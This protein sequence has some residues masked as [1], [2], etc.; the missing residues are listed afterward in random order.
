MSQEV[1]AVS[2]A[3]DGEDVD[4]LIVESLA[5]LENKI[6]ERLDESMEK[7]ILRFE[8]RLA[9][10]LERLMMKLIKEQEIPFEARIVQRIQDVVTSK[11][12]KFEPD[13]TFTDMQN[14]VGS[15]KKF[16]HGMA[17]KVG[18]LESKLEAVEEGA[19]KSTAQ[20]PVDVKEWESRMEHTEQLLARHQSAMLKIR[21]YLDQHQEY[22]DSLTKSLGI[23]T[24]EEQEPGAR[25]YPVRVIDDLRAI[26]TKTYRDTNDQLKQLHSNI[27]DLSSTLTRVAE[28]S[29]DWRWRR[30]TVMQ[31]VDAMQK[32]TRP[33]HSTNAD[34]S[35]QVSSQRTVLEFDNEDADLL[36][37]PTSTVLPYKNFAR[38]QVTT[39]AQS[40]S[41]TTTPRTR[42]SASRS[43]K[44]SS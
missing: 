5:V 28:S 9:K 6:V 31:A 29:D 1:A 20:A 11:K 10:R 34:V 16:A 30:E 33:R 35:S 14:Q 38:E 24:G 17:V 44:V 36:D 42:A 2:S 26:L 7:R 25:T 15:M 19:S 43:A 23:E 32:A 27:V 18:E 12:R 39:P 41:K 40:N 21:D 37:Q 22:I 8:A 4:A 13:D 3:T